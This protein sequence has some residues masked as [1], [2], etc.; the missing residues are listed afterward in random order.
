VP[1]LHRPSR[2]KSFSYLGEYE[3]FVTCCAHER[4]HVFVDSDV[5]DCVRGEML[6]TCEERHFFS[7]V[8]V[9]MPD[10]IHFLVLG[11]TPMAAFRPFMKTLRQRTAV[12]YRHL[13]GEQLWQNGYHERVLRP[14]DNWADIARYIQEN[15]VRAGLVGDS[16][17]YPFCYW[18]HSEA[19]GTRSASRT[20]S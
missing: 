20:V 15:P 1:N 14:H 12:A 13:K 7:R 11:E 8:A 19:M 17:A 4:R 9:F 10:H 6:W 3:Y 2:L 5:V 16:D 18:G